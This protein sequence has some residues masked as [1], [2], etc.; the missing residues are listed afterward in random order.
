[1]AGAGKIIQG[2]AFGAAT[3]FSAMA[4]EPEAKTDVAARTQE[5]APAVANA[6]DYTQLLGEIGASDA[7]VISAEYADCIIKVYPSFGIVSIE[8]NTLKLDGVLNINYDEGDSNFA[9]HVGKVYADLENKTFF[10]MNAKAARDERLEALTFPTADVPEGLPKDSVER[11]YKAAK[12]VIVFLETNKS[13]IA[14]DNRFLRHVIAYK[15]EPKPVEGI[16]RRVDD[17]PA[18]S[19]D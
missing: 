12:A 16:F 4:E 2:L 18:P 5:E 19:N 14:L 11:C 13:D 8:R 7:K 9:T 15:A 3:S 1:M 6:V 10:M 17:L